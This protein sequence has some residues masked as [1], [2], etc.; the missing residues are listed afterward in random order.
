MG[1]LSARHG[2][3]GTGLSYSEVHEKFQSIYELGVTKP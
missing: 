2:G 3:A 1:T